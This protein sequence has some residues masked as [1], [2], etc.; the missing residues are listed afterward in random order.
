[1]TSKTNG[2]QQALAGTSCRL[3]QGAETG[4]SRER[5]FTMAKARMAAPREEVIAPV[6]T[7]SRANAP[8]S[9]LDF[10]LYNLI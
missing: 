8:Q 1:M 2:Y 5:K 7:M 4:T 6:A 9:Y 3:Q 10:H